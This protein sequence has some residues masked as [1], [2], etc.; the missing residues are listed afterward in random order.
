MISA[1]PI[2]ASYSGY[3]SMIN[4]AGCGYFITAKDPHSLISKMKE[5]KLLSAN[6]RKV[7]DSKGLVWL[8]KNRSYEKLADNYLS[9]IF[10]KKLNN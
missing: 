7:M 2:I 9:L 5:M 1:K 4:E 3:P 10:E 8:K 6:E